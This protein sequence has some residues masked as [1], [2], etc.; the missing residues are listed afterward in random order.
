MAGGGV[1]A[2]SGPLKWS[3]LRVSLQHEVPTKRKITALGDCLVIFLRSGHANVSFDVHGRTTTDRLTKGGILFL[4]EG[5]ACEID[6]GAVLES[7]H[8]HLWSGLFSFVGRRPAIEPFVAHDPVLEHL[9]RAV[10]QADLEGLPRSAAFVGAIARA[11]A[12]RLLL[13]GQTGAKDLGRPGGLSGQQLREVQAFVR[14]N[15]EREIGVNAMAGSCGLGSKGFTRAFKKSV[16]QSPYQYVMSARVERAKRLMADRRLG[17]AEIA[18]HCGFCH[19]EHLTRVFRKV[20]GLTPG[21]YRNSA[22]R[23]EDE[24]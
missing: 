21:Q 8:I 16:G 6:P 22:S 1:L 14:E 9:T 3:N 20:T 5:Q 11:I 24:A 4:P 15:I 17:L 12:T 19:Q 10:V 18:L 7:A 13:L 2:T 23:Q